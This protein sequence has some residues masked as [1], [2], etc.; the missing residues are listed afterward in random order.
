MNATPTHWDISAA[1][2]SPAVAQ[3]Q[4]A[5]DEIE[6]HAAEARAVAE[7][8]LKEANR[9]QAAWLAVLSAGQKTWQTLQNAREQ[10]DILRERHALAAAEFD[11]LVGGEFYT[12]EWHRQQHADPM[13]DG[14]VYGTLTKEENPFVFHARTLAALELGIARIESRLPEFERAEADARQAAQHYAKAHGIAHDFGDAEPPAPAPE[15]ESAESALAD[16]PTP[17]GKPKRK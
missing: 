15:T 7:A 1:A 17:T 9:A 4:D 3:L 6:R 13:L 14:W 11:K 16:K 10:L 12:H 8:K 2:N 5:V